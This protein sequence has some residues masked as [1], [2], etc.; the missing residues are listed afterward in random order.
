MKRSQI[1]AL[2]LTLVIVVCAGFHGGAVAAG[3]D[4]VSIAGLL[5]QLQSADEATRMA[6]VQALSQAGPNAIDPL[7][8]VMGGENP[9]A[10][11]AARIAV[12]RM[13]HR[14]AG[15]AGAA[16]R[17]AISRLLAQQ[18]AAANRPVAVRKFAITMLS[19]IGGHEVGPALAAL[20]KDPDMGEMARWTLARIPGQAALDA[21]AAALPGARGEMKIGIINALGA[22]QDKA[23]L[24]AL[25]AAAKSDD[26]AA[27]AAAYAALARFGD[28]RC[29]EILRAAT[30]GGAGAGVTWRETATAWDAYVKLGERMLA[31][32]KRPDAE[33][34]YRH[35]YT[36]APDEQ[37]RCAGVIGLGRVGTPTALKTALDALAA[38]DRDLRGAATEALVAAPGSAATLI[39]AD[40]MSSSASAHKAELAGILGRRHDPAA[41]KALALATE[42]ED[43][44][45]SIAAAQAL[46]QAGDAF[47]VRALVKLLRNHDQQVRD[48]AFLSLVSIK[49]NGATQAEVAAAS[50]REA[51]RAPTSA[52]PWLVRA[53]GNRKDPAAMPV[54]VKALSDKSRRVRLAALEALAASARLTDAAARARLIAVLNS[55]DG[56][57][58]QL[59][60]QALAAVPTSMIG[61]NEKQRMAQAAASAPGAQR[62]G[63]LRIM[64]RWDDASLAP[65]FLQSAADAN[66]DVAVAA[67]D[68]LTRL[69]G[70]SLARDH[71]SRIEGDLVRIGNDA[72][73]AVKAAAAKC[74]LALADHK[75]DKDPAAALPMYHRALA[76]TTDADARRIALHGIAVV[77][78]VESLPV[79]EPLLEGGPVAPEAAAAVMPIADKIA[80]AGDKDK[81]IALY[82]KAIR[83]SS[84][85]GLLTA[86]VERLRALGVEV[87]IAA[88]AGFVTHWWVLGPFAGRKRMTDTDA[89]ATNAP[90]DL[91]APLTFEGEIYHWKAVRVSDPSGMLDLR[92]AVAQ[93]DN[94][95]A[96]AYAEVTSD[97]ARDVMFKI[98]SDDSVIVWLNGRRI[99]A[100]LDDRGYAPDQDLVPTRLQA[101]VNHILFKALNGGADWACGL[102]ITDANNAPLR[103]PQR[104]P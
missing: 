20:L 85:R 46:G 93:Q 80:Q 26:A 2:T 99:H 77:G 43:Q 64:A 72:D 29:E 56:D 1:H 91:S 79:V 49:G 84:D 6:A 63:L 52:R 38:P 44:K 7:F 73:P 65:L 25:A 4:G 58:R 47:A 101:G 48:A 71:S 23:S 104:K 55:S 81:A 54:L 16:Q 66:H 41:V 95:G 70:P 39:I 28:S 100:Y 62:A 37:L 102:R 75:R 90:P 92:A 19:F 86:A 22:R 5:Q 12:Q 57:E 103:L 69:V 88:D 35:V 53:L 36:K 30:G 68:G 76:M 96:Y 60:I 31:A 3:G 42:D 9:T 21:L 94:C 18:A 98:G 78:S 82:R 15:P 13:V 45:V 27:R 59:A 8:G 24:P 97:G 17:P 61:A 34:I 11:L 67:L 89:I 40:R 10:D 87:D 50:S 32:G 33:R 51:G 14:A 74:Y 83:S